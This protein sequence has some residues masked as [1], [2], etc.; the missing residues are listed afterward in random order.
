MQLV[1]RCKLVQLVQRCKRQ[2][3][4]SQRGTQVKSR[5]WARRTAWILAYAQVKDRVS[6]SKLS[7]KH[8]PYANSTGQ[9]GTS[10]VRCE[11][12]SK[13]VRQWSSVAQP[14]Y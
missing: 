6:T 10:T 7:C 3:Y 9:N 1:Q 12:A 5:S 8:P 2:A 14:H 11:R 4:H 13:A